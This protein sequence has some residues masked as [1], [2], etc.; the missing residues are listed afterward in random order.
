M[1]ASHAYIHVAEGEAIR[2]AA[3]IALAATLERGEQQLRAGQLPSEELP[4]RV[5]WEYEEFDDALTKHQQESGTRVASPGHRNHRKA[6]S[7]D[8]RRTR[9]CSEARTPSSL[10]AVSG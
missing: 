2:E 5:R 8:P 4:Q 3:R 6:N 10:K 9:C 7:R 1:L